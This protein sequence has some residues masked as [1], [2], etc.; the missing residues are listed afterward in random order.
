MSEKRKDVRS[1]NWTFLVYPES[2]D[3]NW[4]EIIS[5]NFI[6]WAESPIHNMDKWTEEDEKENPEHKANTPKKE[7]IHIVV[8]WTSN[9]SRE[10]ME[11]FVNLFGG[12]KPQEVRNLKGLLRYFIHLDNPEKAQYSKEDIKAYNGFDVEKYFSLLG[13]DRHIVLGD[14]ITYIV[15]NH[16]TSFSD[17]AFYCKSERQNDWF[18][19]FCDSSFLIKEMIKS[20]YFKSQNKQNNSN[21]LSKNDVKELSNNALEDV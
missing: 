15:E 7:H 2:V 11:E 16:I 19:M 20:E 3:K 21:V 6:E 9:K 10:Q 17:F 13:K 5:K 8:C 4:R 14:M 18:P 12:V 1:K